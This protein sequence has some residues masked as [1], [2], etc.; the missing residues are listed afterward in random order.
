MADGFLQT[1]AANVL[2][3]LVSV[4]RQSDDQQVLLAFLAGR[5]SYAPQSGQISGIL[6]TLHDEMSA[7]LADAVKTENAA[8]DA[9]KSLMQSRLKEKAALTQAIESKSQK[10]GELGVQI[11]SMENDGGDTADA[12]AAD[13]KFL[14]QLEKGCATKTAEWEARSK[15]RAEELVA[16]ADT[17]KMLNDDDALELFKKTLPSAGSMFLQAQISTSSARARALTKIREGMMKVKSPNRV[18]LDLISLALHGKKIGF[19]KVISMI[20]EMVA[21]LKKEQVDDDNKKTYCAEQFDVSDDQKKSLERKASDTEAAIA[22]SKDTIATL[23]EEIAA[24][25]L[26]IQQLDKSVAEAT[27]DRKAEH[28]EYGEL[29]AS[30]SAAKEI[31][32]MAKNR[33][34]QFYNPK[35]AKP[36][37]TT[38]PAPAMV[39]SSQGANPGM[40]PAT[41]GAFNKQSQSNGGVVAMINV[42]IGD[43]DKQMTEAEAEEKN[44]QA[45]YEVLMTDSADKRSADSKSLS[46]KSGTKADT[47]AALEGHEEAKASIA[48]QL[49]ATMKYIASLHAECDW[50]VKYF[51]VRQQARADEVDSLQNAKAV[52]SGADYSFIQRNRGFL[53]PS[54]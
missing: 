54:L 32:G 49:G 45:D 17:I 30:N 43:L 52:L 11:A 27:A 18:G 47:E 31:L 16:L 15:T 14:A 21:T 51:D 33:L 42:L 46:E 38:T 1:G 26:G 28:V 13:Q 29:I 12:L 19:E 44:A 9:Y 5:A 2:R 23:T 34:Q 53:H 20:D 35:L 7:A 10:V 6:Q 22:L 24:L 39:Q 50:L 37:P 25:T 48:K 3:R 40:P 36:D 4:S 41:W 8:I